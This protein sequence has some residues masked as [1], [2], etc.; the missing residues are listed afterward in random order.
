MNMMSKTLLSENILAPKSARLT[1]SIDAQSGTSTRYTLVEDDTFEGT[2]ESGGTDWVAVELEAGTSYVFSVWGTGFEDGLGDSTLTLYDADLAQ[3]GFND[4]TPDGN[5]FSMIEYDATVSG[6]FY[7]E[8]AGYSFPYNSALRDSVTYDDGSIISLIGDYTFQVTDD[9]YTNE[10]VATY[11]TEF[12]W[13]ATGQLRFDVT[14]GETLTYNTQ[15]LNADGR[16]LAEWAFEAWEEMSGINFQSSNSSSAALILDDNSSGAFAGPNMF[17]PATGIITQ[18]SVNVGTSWLISNGTEIDSYSF[19]TYLHEI[20]HALGLGHSGNYDG[21][22]SYAGGDAHFRNDSYQTTVMSYFDQEQNTYVLGDLALPITPMI[23]DIIA[24]QQ[25]YG[26]GASANSGNTTWGE[27]TNVQGYLG[28]ILSAI[29]D[30][31]SI[32]D[33][34]YTG[35]SI[36][37]TIFDTGG[38]DLV[39]FAGNTDGIAV[40]LTPGGANGAYDNNPNV[41]I[42][43]DTILENV[44]T[45]T[46]SDTIV[47]NDVANIIIAGEGNDSITAGGGNDNITGDLGRDTIYG[48]SGRDTIVGGSSDD[49]LMGDG[50]NDSIL[51]ESAVDSIDGGIG[52]DTLRGGTGSDSVYGGDG[53]DSV[54]GNTGVDFVY[55]GAGDDWIS[56]GNGADKAYGGDGDDTIIGRTGWDTIRGDAGDDS[57]TGSEGEDHLYGGTGNDYLAGGSGRDLL[58][59]EDGNDEMYGN[60][61]ADSLLGGAGNDT[62]YGASGDDTI[63]G[64]DG[65]DLIFGSQGLDRLEG[66]AGNDTVIGGTQADTFIFGAGDG[67]DMMTNFEAGADEIRLEDGI[68]GTAAN[69][70]DVID[71]FGSI[72]SAGV[73]LTFG[74]DLT[75]TFD[76]LDNYDMLSESLLVIT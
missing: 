76:T 61:G 62:M 69:G 63:R 29:V 58:R 20:G 36:S 12:N 56:P 18:S 60:L 37:F 52:D 21:N 25:L 15:G 46:G 50:G 1:E 75:L 24:I 64:G 47:G 73:V 57:L 49:V 41:V 16:Q 39:N 70:Q 74:T 45:G 26:T 11:L 42:A 71:M 51:G 8:I 65:D 22:A 23:A 66:G 14:A 10:Q 7:V 4:D 2:I 33:S 72:T 59:G 28:D 17:D 3:V 44:T 53:N 5:L 13:G 40:D 54:L 34:I 32:S 30:N 68:A 48:G 67:N 27:D 38:I 31:E 6:T 35:D 55:G 19:L 9:I 43:E